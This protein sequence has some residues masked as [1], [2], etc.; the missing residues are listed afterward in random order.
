MAT[1][2]ARP[3]GNIRPLLDPVFS[4][5]RPRAHG[6]PSLS[7]EFVTN[8]DHPLPMP[9]ADTAYRPDLSGV[10]H[11]GPEVRPHEAPGIPSRE[12]PGPRPRMTERSNVPGQEST[13]PEPLSPPF[14]VALQGDREGSARQLPGNRDPEIVRGGSREGEFSEPKK[15]GIDPDRSEL[16]SK[17]FTPAVQ[18]ASP[19]RASHPAH[20][21]G[22]TDPRRVPGVASREP[23]EINIHIGRI[24]VT[25]VQPAAATGSGPRARRSG[26]SLDDYLRQRDRRSP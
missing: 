20:L 10:P 12:I 22:S 21:P 9:R 24:E 13:P 6:D 17:S 4:G 1:A 23:D 3:A 14:L 8:A 5:S 2:A 16:P 25:A 18:G 7:P 15:G 11:L 19:S 26:T